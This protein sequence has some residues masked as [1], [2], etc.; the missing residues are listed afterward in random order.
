MYLILAQITNYFKPRHLF[1]VTSKKSPQSN[2]TKSNPN[3]IPH[4]GAKKT[5]TFFATFVLL[6]MS[7]KDDIEIFSQFSAGER[8]CLSIPH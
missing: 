3:P 8:F 2:K 7:N 1:S 5:C 4:G 6:W